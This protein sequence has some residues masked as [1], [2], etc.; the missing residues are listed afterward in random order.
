MHTH[1]SMLNAYS[2]ILCNRYINIYD[3]ITNIYI[4]HIYNIYILHQEM[5]AFSSYYNNFLTLFYLLFSD[6]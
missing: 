6:H 5:K 4:K 3:I 2:V 1:L